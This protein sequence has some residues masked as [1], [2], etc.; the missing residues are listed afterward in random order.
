MERP[1][2]RFKRF[3]V[4]QAPDVHPVGI[5]GILLGAWV[6]LPDAGHVLEVGTGTGLV[7]LIMAQRSA[8]DVR[9]DAIDIHPG[10]VALARK[11]A[12]C[13]PWP[14]KISCYHADAKTWTGGQHYQLLVS[15]P[16]FFSGPVAPAKEVRLRARHTASLRGADLLAL[17]DR[18]VD[19]KGSVAL[20]LPTGYARELSEQGACRGWYAVQWVD[21]HTMPGKSPTRVLLELN[22]APG[23]FIRHSMALLDDQKAPDAS[24]RMLCD[25]FYE[26]W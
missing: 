16:P 26:A 1:P 9:I 3:A 20:I 18:V 17:A 8:P 14:D 19:P 22:R 15:N 12:S 13:A 25:A 2:F 24:F 21:V 7:S 11:N 10:S 4:E 6:P 5:D 23:S